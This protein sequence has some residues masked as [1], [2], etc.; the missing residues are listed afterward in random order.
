MVAEIAADMAE[1]LARIREMRRSGELTAIPE[2]A[3]D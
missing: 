1:Q 3:T 2:L